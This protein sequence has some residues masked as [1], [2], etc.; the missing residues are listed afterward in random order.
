MARF[1]LSALAQDDLAQILVVSAERWGPEG[2]RRYA[3]VLAA[4]M[5]KVAA[6]PN[7]AATRAR[8][9]LSGAVRSFHLRHAGIGSSKIRVRRPV[10]VLFYRVVRP[11]LVEIVR[12]LHE[13]M[14]PSR[15]LGVEPEE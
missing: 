4:A 12:A 3:A 5:R 1:R 14:E 15:H 11:G 6:E 7:G 9:D 10:H 13:R 2:R 8:A